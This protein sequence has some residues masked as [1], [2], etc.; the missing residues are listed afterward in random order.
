MDLKEKEA[1]GEQADRHW[2]YVA[3]AALLAK[4]LDRT[5]STVLDIG[6]GL[7]WFSRWLLDNDLVDHAVCVDTGYPEDKT[8]YLENGKAISYCRSVEKVDAD[9]FLLMDV[10][11][12][13]DDDV[14]MLKEYWDKAPS[15]SCFVVTVPAFNFLW[16]G[17]DDFLEHKRRYT[18]ASL[19]TT[20]RA[21]GAQPVSL[22]YFYGVVFPLVALVRLFK[23]KGQDGGSDM[24]PV[25]DILN[26]LLTFICRMELKFTKM[27]KLFGLTVVGKFYK[28]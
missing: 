20:I 26:R 28:P 17:H 9:L 3:K 2:Y 25:P 6:A 1:L 13:V 12:H 22:H 11:E 21:V 19:E 24:K 16:S 5:H 15:G 7:G 23:G 14:A 10:L 4:H 8:E 18:M 27:N